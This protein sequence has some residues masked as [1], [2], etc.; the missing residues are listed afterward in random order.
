MKSIIITPATLDDI[1][2][3]SEIKMDKHL[4]GH[5]PIQELLLR[6]IKKR[7]TKSLQENICNFVAKDDKNLYGFINCSVLFNEQAKSAEI[8]SLYIIP[9]MR[10]R[11]LGSRLCFAAINNLREKKFQSV[12][13]WVSICSDAAKKFFESNGFIVITS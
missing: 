7:W 10:R 5:S 3:I 9:S 4:K 2:K 6:E 12:V 13:V 1:Q 8:N 11:G